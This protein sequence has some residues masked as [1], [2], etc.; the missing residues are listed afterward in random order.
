MRIC[1]FLLSAI[2]AS[3]SGSVLQNGKERMDC[4]D[5]ISEMQGLGDLIKMGSGRIEVIGIYN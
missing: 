2:S 1:L 3:L 5:C 4:I